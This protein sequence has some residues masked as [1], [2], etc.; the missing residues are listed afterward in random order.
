MAK[1]T[2][3]SQYQKREPHANT[4]LLLSPPTTADVHPHPCPFPPK[5]L[6]IIAGTDINPHSGLGGR[7]PRY[8]TAPASWHCLCIYSPGGTCSGMQAI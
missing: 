7:P 4:D 1:T 3:L 2:W 5:I 8:A 6:P